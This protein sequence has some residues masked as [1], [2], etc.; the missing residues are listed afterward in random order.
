LEQHK[1]HLSF[2]HTATDLRLDQEAKTTLPLCYNN[3][4]AREKTV[5]NEIN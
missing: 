4:P 2:I 3:P 1:S 5:V